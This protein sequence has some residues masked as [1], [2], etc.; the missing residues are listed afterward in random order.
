MF[1]W[2]PC[3]PCT[4]LYIPFFVD[5][6]KLPEILSQAGKAG[7]SV[8]PPPQAI[9][10]EYSPGSWWWQFRELI[11]MVKGDEIGSKYNERQPMVRATFDELEKRFAAEAWKAEQKAIAL[12]KTGCTSETVVVLDE[13]MA[14]FIEEGLAAVKDLKVKMADY[15]TEV[16]MSILAH[17]KKGRRQG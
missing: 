8:T 5:G 14:K 13:F 16:T 15:Q 12:K 1:W 7:K 10:D 9:Q 4:G 6:S 3:P 2:T 11:D 17:K